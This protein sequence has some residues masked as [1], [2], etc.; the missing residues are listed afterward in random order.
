MKL[1]LIS[2]LLLLLTIAPATVTAQVGKKQPLQRPK[3]G[4]VLSGGGAKGMAHIGFLKVM[5]EAGIRPDYITGT[6]MGSLVGALYALGYSAS[7]IEKIALEQDWEMLLSNQ[8]PLSQIAMEEKEYYGRYLLEL[9]VKGLKIS[10]PSGLI[11]GQALNNLLIRLTRGA[12]GIQDFNKLPIPFACVATDLA[13]GD[14]V[15]LRQGFLPE[16][17]RASM[18]IPTVFTP[19]KLDGRMLVDGGL[20]QNFP[21]QEALDMGA[22][23]VIGVNVGSGLE[24]EHNL[25]SMIDVL[26]QATFFTSASNLES[27]KKKTD[28]LVDV[29]PSLEGY[30]NTGSFK[31]TKEI[32][33]I[34][35]QVARQYEDSLQS[36]AKYF[37]SFQE[38]MHHPEL[39]PLQDSVHLG[40]LYIS[41]TSTMPRRILRR[42]L[43]LN[44]NETTTISSIEDR[45]EVLFGTGH[46]NKVSYAMVPTDSS[47]HLQVNVEEAAKGL[48]KTAIFYDSENRAGATINFTHRNLL[49][50]G[51]RF[52]AE[53]DLGQNIRT[54]INYLKYMGYRNQLAAKLSSQYFK[55]DFAL[56]NNSG[57]KVAILQRNTNIGT[58]GWQTTTNN[59]WTLGQQLEYKLTRLYPQVAGQVNLDTMTVDI[60]QL[61]QLKVRNWS[62]SSFFKLNT[63]D[64]H[65]Y[66]TKGWKAELQGSFIFGSRFSVRAKE[67]H[68]EWEDKMGHDDMDPYFK[69]ALSANGVVPLRHNLSLML[70]QGLVMYTNNDLPIGEETLVGGYTSVLP[71]MVEYRAAEPFAYSTDN[72]LYSGLGLQV[73]LRKKL[74]LQTSTTLL[75][76]SLLQ[77]SRNLRGRNSRLGYSA[78]L[79]YL[80]PFGPITAGL[81][82]E[83]NSDWRG[84][85]SLGFR[86][87]W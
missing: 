52:V 61:E 35:E 50:E 20:V 32:I 17:L 54:D 46:F 36:L 66:P 60:T 57:S 37:N 75:N 9:P 74:Y 45:I 85:I 62:F 18:A 27:E 39:S 12:H 24:P 42:R 87:P 2:I 64:R 3:I 29:L 68:S 21:V 58:L 43:R 69:V 44:E 41:G 38:P 11:E 77:G 7:E 70:G 63:L 22:D 53:A 56:F 59:S 80:T 78:T 83:R 67:G 8:V 25:K 86:L 82:H 19:M 16:A 13:T 28:L 10:F 6:S 51:S 55:N 73:E 15:V 47:H 79:G 71:D 48:L 34:G 26:V 30:Y 5:E 81:A 4:L 40:Q 72:L 84:F 33:R 23:F 14:K 76:T 1:H 65:Y 49:W 31:N